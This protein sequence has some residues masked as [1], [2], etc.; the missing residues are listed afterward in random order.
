LF[1]SISRSSSLA[2]EAMLQKA[3]V[4]TRVNSSR[5]PDDDASLIEPLA[6]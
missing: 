4:S 5:A 3:R 6:A 2:P 1:F